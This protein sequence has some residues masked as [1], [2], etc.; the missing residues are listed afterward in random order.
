MKRLPNGENL[1]APSARGLVERTLPSPA[2]ASGRAILWELRISASPQRQAPILHSFGTVNRGLVESTSIHR[3]SRISRRI[4]SMLSPWVGWFARLVRSCKLARPRWQFGLVSNLS[5][6][7]RMTSETPAVEMSTFSASQSNLLRAFDLRSGRLCPRLVPLRERFTQQRSADSPLDGSQAAF[8]L[9]WW[10]SFSQNRYVRPVLQTPALF[11]ELGPFAS[12]RDASTFLL[13]SLR[14]PNRKSPRHQDS[15]DHF[16]SLGGTASAGDSTLF[17]ST[18]NSLL[19]RLQVP[20]IYKLSCMNRGVVG[21]WSCSLCQPPDWL[22]YEGAW[23]S[24]SVSGLM[25]HWL[26]NLPAN[27]VGCVSYHP[28]HQTLWIS[29]NSSNASTTTYCF[30]PKPGARVAPNTCCR[31]SMRRSR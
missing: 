3:A 1:I 9:T 24:L 11:I 19:R 25:M 7:E 20:P 14:S 6:C 31:W 12:V 17:G 10:L 21:R 16:P 22:T 27:A 28:L 2:T 15:N 23:Q 5:I 13:G 4:R 18:S 30:F 26:D 29:S 8:T